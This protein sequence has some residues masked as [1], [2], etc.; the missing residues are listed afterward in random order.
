MSYLITTVSVEDTQ[1]LLV[2]RLLCHTEAVACQ[3]GGKFSHLWKD[4]EFDIYG[5]L[6]YLGTF[7]IEDKN[8]NSHKLPLSLASWEGRCSL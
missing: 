4:K 6:K 2:W 3:S 1:P 5:I 7:P 8:L